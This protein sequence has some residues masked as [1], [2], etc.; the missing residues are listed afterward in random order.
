M[1]GIRVQYGAGRSAPPGWLS[2][3]A[4]PRLWLERLP[5]LG[6]MARLRGG[7][8]PRE[9][10][11]GNIVDGL[12]VR[13]GSA[14]AVFASH[15]LE[16]LS[17]EDFWRAVRNTQDMLAPGGVFRLVVPD[18]KHRAERYVADAAVGDPNAA[19][20]FIRE[21]SLGRERRPRSL[22]QLLRDR[23]GASQHLW[24]WD[25]ASMAAAL[26]HVGFVAVRRCALGDADDPAFAEVEAPNRF[27][28][29]R[30][31][32]AELAMEARKAG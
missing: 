12:K 6:A 29:G 8:F 4:S 16:H 3:D 9:V 27:R 24:M 30:T 31:G 10:R 11:F 21:T 23:F 20:R 7:R 18:L 26:D 32:D 5:A 17:F 14:S 1:T 15:V 28:F 2:F 25:E 13:P 22:S 19:L